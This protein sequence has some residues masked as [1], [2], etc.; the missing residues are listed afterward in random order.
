MKV[1]NKPV[2]C[3]M[4]LQFRF[5]N[6][7]SFAEEAVLDL[8]ATSIREHANR[9]ID[10]NGNKVLPVAAI[11]GA[12]ASGKSNIF[13]AFFSMARDIFALYGKNENHYLVT[14]YIFSKTTEKKPT[15][16][17]VSINIDDKEYRY[18]FVRNQLQVFDEWLYT[19]KFSKG[20]KSKEK[21]I[22]Y[23]SGRKV[24]VGKLN[25]AEKKE[26]E[27]LGSMINDNELLI[28]AIGLRKRSEYRKVYEWFL[29]TCFTQDFSDDSDEKW[30]TEFAAKFL[31]ENKKHFEDV[32]G[33]L[34]KFDKSI[35]RLEITSEKDADLNE[36]FTV[37]S[38]HHDE[39]GNEIRLPFASESSGTKKMFALATLLIFSL[40]SGLV[41]WVDE[42]DAKL[43]PL[44]LRYILGLYCS[45]D[46]NVG[47][48]Q[49]IFSSH[50]L[51]C[52]DSSDLRRDE[53]WFVEKVNQVST[54]YSLYDFKEDEV[55]IRSDLS[56]GKHYLSG[57]FGAIP[58]QDEEDAYGG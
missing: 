9:L 18:G 2:R 17:E 48:G 19:K 36:R 5:K 55:A 49:L 58:F 23:R 25:Q 37:Y 27:Y 6:Y 40:K 22:F 35:I 4:L 51:V 8:T 43:H 38:Y 53:I 21:M 12:N 15:E 33:L 11:F 45:R 1:D 42:L 39:K 56:F 46:E 20:T 52:L 31:Y 32:E 10:K 3:T 26:L 24:L 50:N 57:R 13:S 30:G 34:R 54:L 44:I 47:N 28:T 16:Y 7:K 29:F 41:L 14:P